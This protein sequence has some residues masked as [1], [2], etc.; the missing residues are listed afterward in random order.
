MRPC[1]REHLLDA[2]DISLTPRPS[3]NRIGGVLPSA[4]AL[5]AV[6]QMLAGESADQPMSGMPKHEWSQPMQRWGAARDSRRLSRLFCRCFLQDCDHALDNVIRG[7]IAGKRL[8]TVLIHHPAIAGMLTVSTDLE[9][10]LALFNSPRRRCSN[11]GAPALQAGIFEQDRAPAGAGLGGGHS[12]FRARTLPKKRR[13]VLWHRRRP[14]RQQAR[15]RGRII[16]PS[17]PL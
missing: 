13:G 3:P 2:R 12:D 4:D 17:C 7:R 6:R 11:K 14:R 9:N 8:D 1:L 5:A 10:S 16:G 15:P